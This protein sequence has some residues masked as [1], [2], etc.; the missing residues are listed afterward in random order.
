MSG[1]TLLPVTIFRWD[2]TEQS[3]EKRVIMLN[4]N[5]IDF[6][7]PQTTLPNASWIA[8][9]LVQLASGVQL[10]TVPTNWQPN[11]EGQNAQTDRRD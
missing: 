3:Y 10:Y 6:I 11:Q 4:A 2:E 1:S 9:S 7:E 5:N 8:A